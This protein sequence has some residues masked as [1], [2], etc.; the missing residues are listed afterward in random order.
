MFW[1]VGL[2][3]VGVF[4]AFFL[5]SGPEWTLDPRAGIASEEAL[6]G[7]KLRPQEN[8]PAF[9]QMKAEAQGQA[10]SDAPDFSLQDAR[11]KTWTL[12]DVAKGKPSL[13][14]F[15]EKECP[16]CLGAKPFV[17]RLANL[18]PN[19]LQVVGVIDSDAD[20]AKKWA[21]TT[22]AE[23]P[24]LLDPTLRTIRA[25]RAERGV[26]TTLVGSDGTIL[27]NY[28]GYSKSM[29]QE[30]SEKIAKSVGIPPRSIKTLGAPD[31]MTSGCLFPEELKP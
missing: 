20:V 17:D 15:I 30:L 7:L 26:Y 23:W 29:L 24:I 28:P 3:S 4:G 1:A 18:Y 21:E 27:A 25:F 8:H 13:F 19:E 22:A 16:C 6:R 12:S 31:E 5:P 9:Q 14:Y 2:I 10:G 11:G